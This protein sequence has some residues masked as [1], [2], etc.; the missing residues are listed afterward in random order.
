MNRGEREPRTPHATPNHPRPTSHGGCRAPSLRRLL[1][2]AAVLAILVVAAALRLP[3]LAQRPM[4][5]D[6]ANQAVKSWRLYA[7]GEN[8]YDTADHHGPTLYWLTLPSLALS[9]AKDLAGTREV[10]YRIVTVLFGLGLIPLVLLLT[11]GLGRGAVLVAALLAGISPGLVFYSRYYIQET[12]LLFF[13]LAALGCGWRY[14]RTRRL[15]W[16]VA[17]GA[18]VGMMHATKETWILS[19]A[20]ALA[21]AGLTW[22][23][24]RLRDTERGAGSGERGVRFRTPCSLLPAPSFHLL[25]AVLTAC[26]VAAAFFS[27]FGRHW[28][29]PRESILAYANYFRRGSQPGEHSEPWYYYLQVFFAD[30]PSKRIFWSE[31]LIALLA[32]AGGIDALGQRKAAE[33]KALPRFLT[34]YTFLLT[35]LYSL[36]S[37]KTPWC[38]LNFLIGM[39]LLAGVGAAAIFRCL[40]T[41]SASAGAASHPRW[42]I[43]LVF[44]AAA[45]LLSAGAG[46]LGWQSY[47]LNFNPRFLADPLNPYCYAHTPPPLPRLV[48]RLDYVAGRAPEGHDL[49]IQVVVT[50]NY[51][52]LPWYLRNFNEKRVGY[53]LDAKVW[54][55]ERDRYP[56][57]AILICSSDVDTDDYATRL[58]DYGD[59]DFASLRPGVLLKVYIRKDLCITAR[60]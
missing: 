6:E 9:G 10:D 33:A 46:H 36:I 32:L 41:R 24:S 2:A 27:M 15:I 3:R 19:A 13:T 52:P 7:Q 49:W 11:D 50:D 8:P 28:A 48:E 29:G 55:R 37:Y 12:L 44:A 47:Q 56:P 30:W 22:C 43:G 23:W 51:W 58:A 38:G 1:F 57:P 42:R 45:I 16:I 59:P 26:L 35:L 53:W 25:V 20:A 40:R 17:A 31:G 14:V 18:S 21:A 60:P 54:K 4:H 5:A 34:F 39:I